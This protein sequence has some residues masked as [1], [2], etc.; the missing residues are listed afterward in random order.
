MME[1]YPELLQCR[2]FYGIEYEKLELF[3][4]CVGAQVRYYAKNSLIIRAGEPIPHI[5][6]VVK[7]QIKTFHVRNV[8]TE[9]S[10]ETLGPGGLFG[11][12]YAILRSPS[13]VSARAL[14]DCTLLFLRYSNL[15]AP[16]KK[17]CAAHQ[18]VIENLLPT[19]EEKVIMQARKIEY[20]HLKSIRSKLA[21]YLL[22]TGHMMDATAFYLPLNR[23]QM[24][25]YLGVSR[26]SMTREL[27]SMQADGLIE[28]SGRLVR[29][30]A[31]A[32]LSSCIEES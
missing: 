21:A 27:S 25:E 16:C 8:T 2:L 32:A 19:L 14:T 28:Y 26:A 20:L 1:V 24:A 11:P 31:P 23:T 9:S 10:I 3:L 15:Y 12:A 22:D 4:H 7:G 18:R 5:I 6:L 30:N 13:M 29:L 17:A